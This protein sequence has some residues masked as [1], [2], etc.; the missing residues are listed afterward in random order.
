MGGPDG[1]EV[2]VGT[3]LVVGEGGKGGGG[4]G[5]I[6]ID[7]E[8]EGGLGD[9]AKLVAGPVF[10]E[11]ARGEWLT[12]DDGK[13][14][15]GGSGAGEGGGVVGGI[16]IEEDNFIVGVGLVAEGGDGFGDDGRFIAGG[17][18]DGN[19]RRVGGGGGGGQAGK[20]AEISKEG[21]IENDEGENYECEDD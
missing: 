4:K 6:S 13:F 7:E 12:R 14:V 9:L 20:L 10:A 1:E 17:D 21:D 5:D 16:I 11:P 19:E 15:R 8:K 2:G 18:K 3:G